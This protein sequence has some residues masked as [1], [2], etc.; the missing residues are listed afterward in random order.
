VYQKMDR[1]GKIL[2]KTEWIYPY[3]AALVL[4]A[5]VYYTIALI[6]GIIRGLEMNAETGSYVVS[7]KTDYVF[8]VMA[9]LLCGMVFW[10]WY[11]SLA[12][13]ESRKVLKKLAALKKILPI[14]GL[15]F[16]GQCV[17]AGILCLFRSA[18]MNAMIGYDDIM[19]QLLRGSPFMVLLF[20]V[21]IAPMTEEMIFRGVILY[22]AK[23]EFPFWQANVLQGILF[24]I[25]H[26]NLVQG[27]FAALTGFLL[28]Y[29]CLKYETVWA[30]VF[31]HM[32]N[33]SAAFLIAGFLKNR[34]NGL[35][36]AVIGSALTLCAFIAVSSIEEDL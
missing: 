18:F 31:M 12:Q 23:K 26:G 33:N 10:Y 20:L 36:V 9:I 5:V 13:K 4:Q 15:G 17:A 34:Y 16:G 24:G 30:S 8:L 27:I 29:V 32:V 6:Y 3:F 2:R 28:G 11:R 21:M 14:V 1:I 22:K 19:K 25:Y 35:I 7:Q